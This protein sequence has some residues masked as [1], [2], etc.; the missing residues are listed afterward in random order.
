MTKHKIKLSRSES[1]TIRHSCNRVGQNYCVVWQHCGLKLSEPDCTV[2][3]LVK[4]GKDC[5]G[6]AVGYLRYIMACEKSR[7]TYYYLTK[8]RDQMELPDVHSSKIKN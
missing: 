3:P 4:L 5:N 2:C 7:L 8:G 6:N 1:A